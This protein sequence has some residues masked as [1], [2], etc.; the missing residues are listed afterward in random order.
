VRRLSARP[1]AI[2][3]TGDIAHSGSAAEYA[4]A[5]ELLERIGVPVYPLPGNHD[6]RDEL[7]SAFAVSG[8]DGA[9][10]QY[11]VDLGPLRLVLADT[12]VPGEDRGELDGS[13]LAWLDEALGAAD[14]PT[15][16]A[17]HHP[18]IELG[19][20]I[21]DDIGLAGAGDLSAVLERH[22][23]VQLVVGGHVHRTIAAPFA[24][25]Y[26]LSVPS[27]YMQGVVEH[28]VDEIELVDEEPGF[29]VHTLVGGRV[30]SRIEPVERS[31][32]A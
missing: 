5:R 10:V 13:R 15:V 31:G 29:A 22:P 9:P 27:T 17:L 8:E 20:P 7:R 4:I 12:T 26:V 21:W 19:I 25:R 3:V 11:D 18:P 24:G 2:L 1:A 32:P 30:V 16:V 23:H 6:D 28:G 14:K